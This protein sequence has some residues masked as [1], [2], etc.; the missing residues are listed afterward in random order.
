MGLTSATAVLE[1]MDAAPRH[2][3]ITGGT[4]YLGRELIP[5]L[6]CRGHRVRALVRPGSGSSLP[7][8]CGVIRGNA[9]DGSTFAGKISPADTFV[10][11]VG[12]PHPSPAK[13]KQFREV[14]LVSVRESVYAAKAA[15]VAHFIY[16]SVAQP[17]PVMR[18][19]LAVRA[20]GE[21]LI[22]A[23]GFNATFIRPFYV[24]GPGHWW[25]HLILPLFWLAEIL[26]AWR[27]AAR[28]LKPVTLAQTIHL[29][30]QA[31][32]HPGRGVRIVD[33]EAMRNLRLD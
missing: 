8:G 14:D 18:E 17:A 11:L 20:E 12:V 33:A 27:A 7:R 24:L 26:P 29:L 22:R 5:Q 2:I 30:V 32:E 6:L 1:R 21:A 23:A 28:R 25:P 3:F 15:G 16:L 31:V 19:Y 13:A 10:Q 9:L 4:G